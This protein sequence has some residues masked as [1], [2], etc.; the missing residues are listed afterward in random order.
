MVSGG[1]F[2]CWFPFKMRYRANRQVLI[3]RQQMT[4]LMILLMIP[5]MCSLLVVPF[6]SHQQVLPITPFSPITLIVPCPLE[7]SSTS[8]LDDNLTLASIPSYQSGT[9]SSEETH[10]L[11]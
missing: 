1:G 2:F 6:P 11:Y 3:A 8:M 7:T 5:H 9:C 10:Y 4:P